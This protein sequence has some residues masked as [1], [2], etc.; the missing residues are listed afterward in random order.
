MT[1][2]RGL[3]HHQQTLLGWIFPKD[4]VLAKV[5]WLQATK[6]EKEFIERVVGGSSKINEKAGEPDLE[7]QMGT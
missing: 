1:L 2:S 5:F 4:Y 6:A 3:Y 7:I